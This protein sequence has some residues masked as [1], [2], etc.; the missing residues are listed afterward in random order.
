MEAAAHAPGHGA[1]ENPPAGSPQGAAGDGDAVPRPDDAAG[2][3][4]QVDGA[5]RN[6]AKRKRPTA[7]PRK[8]PQ[9][10]TFSWEV[11]RAGLPQE[12]RQVLSGWKRTWLTMPVWSVNIW[13]CRP[14]LQSQILTV[15][16]SLPEAIM[17]ES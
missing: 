16:S 14:T 2:P 4:A 7:K 5:T 13:I 9:P 17:R 1:G 11:Q 15:R 12:A 8:P 6:P 3:R 10:K